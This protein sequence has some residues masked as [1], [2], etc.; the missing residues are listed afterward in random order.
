MGNILILNYGSIFRR[1]FAVSPHKPC[2]KS[3]FQPQAARV[4]TL[5]QAQVTK[6][7]WQALG[8][9]LHFI[10]LVNCYRFLNVQKAFLCFQALET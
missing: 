5:P 3:R 1:H 9:I 8:L 2:P 6:A 10:F 4:Q 7:T